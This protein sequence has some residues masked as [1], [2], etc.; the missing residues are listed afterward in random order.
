MTRIIAAGTSWVKRLKCEVPDTP[1]LLARLQAH[2]GPP[3][4]RTPTQITLDPQPP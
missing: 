1:R 3:P 4:G 2:L